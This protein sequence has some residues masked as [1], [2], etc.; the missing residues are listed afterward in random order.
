MSPEPTPTLDLRGPAARRLPALGEL[1]PLSEAERAMAARTWRGRMVNEHISARVFAALLPQAMRAGLD[2][3]RI[4]ELPTYAADELRHGELCAAVVLA[5]G[6]EPVA[7]YPALEE[8][9]EH[10]EVSPQEGLLRNLLSVCCL[11]ETVAVSVIRA[12]HAELEG[13]VLG[14]VLSGILADEVRHARFG[15]RILGELAPTLDTDSRARLGCYLVDALVHQVRYELPRLPLNGPVRPELGQVGVCD[16]AFARELFFDTVQQVI[17][18]QL[19]AAGLPARAAWG[20]ALDR[21]RV[22]PAG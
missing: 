14:D 21:L 16:G 22:T 15:W 1:P 18:P 9:P 13:S 17:L 3:E 2:P 8:V 20:E 6:H 4:A 11:S 5:L 7:P 19:E 10:P 12:E